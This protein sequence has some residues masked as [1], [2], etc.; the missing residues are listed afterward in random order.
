M[1]MGECM[2]LGG[3]TKYNK[4]CRSIFFFILDIK[5]YA[6]GYFILIVIEQVGGGLFDLLYISIDIYQN[7]LI[8]MQLS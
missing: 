4:I 2:Y 5:Q 1:L 8:E 6:F 7:L 3:D